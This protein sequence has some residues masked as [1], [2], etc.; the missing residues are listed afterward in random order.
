MSVN[1]TPRFVPALLGLLLLPAVAAAAEEVYVIDELLVGVHAEKDLDSAIIKVFPTGT[2]LE[3]LERDGELA[4]IQG[5]EDVN[6]W[7]D[8]AYL[9]KQP[10]AKVRLTALE[11]EKAALEQRLTAASTAAPGSGGADADPAAATQLEAVTRENTELK[12]KLSD[13]RLRAG[14]LQSEVTSLRAELRE[15]TTP[16]DAR[17]V[18]IER[19]REALKGEL[20]DARDQIS[21]LETR[22]SLN[23]TSAM[24]PLVL[25][26]YAWPIGVT[27]V[28]LLAAAFGAGIYVVD[29]LSR[30][31]HGGF[32]I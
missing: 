22:G 5:P 32:R 13:E 3:V 11:A 9:T 2:R 17:I 20:E 28:V 27:L 6:G 8:G 1:P 12:G 16:P 7:V 30:R 29:I 21:E 10:P 23:A 14:Q 15:N 4:R 18:E 26:A 31:R 24:V 25:E 19:E